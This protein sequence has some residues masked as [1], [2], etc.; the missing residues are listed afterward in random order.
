MNLFK[1]ISRLKWTSIFRLLRICLPNFLF[2]WPTYRATKECMQISTKHFGRKH[3]QNGQANAF[4]HALW[5]ILIAKKCITLNQSIDKVLAWTKKITDWHEKAFFSNELPMNMDYHNNAV[6]RIVF[7]E[8]PIWLEEQFVNH[9]LKLA[10]NAIKIDGASDLNLFK[11]QLVYI[12]DD[13]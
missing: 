10:F 4:R 2:L 3:Y 8:N 1:T 11:N 12:S 6:G 13:H 9:L 5:N 7:G